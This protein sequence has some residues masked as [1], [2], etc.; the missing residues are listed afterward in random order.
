MNFMYPNFDEEKGGGPNRRLGGLLSVE[1][2]GYIFCIQASTVSMSCFPLLFK[3]PYIPH[4]AS[5]LKLIR[6][7]AKPIIKYHKIP[8][9][10]PLP[11]YKLLRL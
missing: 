1:G 8:V 3:L 11:A 2:G 6:Y 10:Y 7:P 5:I 4:P 9:I